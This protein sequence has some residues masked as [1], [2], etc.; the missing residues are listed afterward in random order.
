MSERP[1]K[2]QEKVMDQ[3]EADQKKRRGMMLK[4]AAVGG[5]TAMGVAS[6]WQSGDAVVGGVL[7][8]VAAAALIATF[9][10]QVPEMGVRRTVERLCSSIA[11]GVA[12]A[13]LMDMAGGGSGWRMGASVVGAMVAIGIWTAVDKKRQRSMKM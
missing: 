2:R 4:A 6:G 13:A 12:G 11:G 3:R 9:E 8:L 1:K 7:G 5:L 10:T